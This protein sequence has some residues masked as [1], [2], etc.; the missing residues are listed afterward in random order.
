M[1]A[2]GAAFRALA[3]D[4]FFT[5][6]AYAMPGAKGP[7]GEFLYRSRFY[8]LSAGTLEHYAARV[9]EYVEGLSRDLGLD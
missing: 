2:E 1:Q 6:F 3:S 7:N 5:D 8:A 4:R 9:R